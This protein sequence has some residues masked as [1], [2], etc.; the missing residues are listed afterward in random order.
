VCSFLWWWRF[1]ALCLLLCLLNPLSEVITVLI[2]SNRE[3]EFSIPHT[4]SVCLFVRL[5]VSRHT[6]EFPKPL[7]TNTN[8]AQ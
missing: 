2:K 5:C 4:I 6:A 3:P 1:V 8:C 7:T